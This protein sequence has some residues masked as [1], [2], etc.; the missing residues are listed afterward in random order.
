MN[1][2]KFVTI[3]VFM[4]ILLACEAR[5]GRFRRQYYPSTYQSYQ[6]PVPAAAYGRTAYSPIATPNGAYDVGVESAGLQLHLLCS[7]CF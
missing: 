4:G 6:Y 2:V 3:L 1:G 7:D 5:P